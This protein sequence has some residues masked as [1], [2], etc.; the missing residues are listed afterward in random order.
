MSEGG[1]ER[2]KE[3]REAGREGGRKE[4]TQNQDNGICQR[5]LGK[6]T[7]VAREKEEHT[8]THSHAL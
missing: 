7:D 3:G 2:R 1:R 6:I 5:L 4:D 8:S